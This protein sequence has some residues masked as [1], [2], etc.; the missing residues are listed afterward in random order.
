MA[1]W[2]KLLP[3]F[4]KHGFELKSDENGVYEWRRD[5]KVIKV[6]KTLE[7]GQIV[8][9]CRFFEMFLDTT[10]EV[11]SFIAPPDELDDPTYQMIKKELEK[12]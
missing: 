6:K 8:I 9:S 10:Q 11:L 12:W 1:K 2:S 5:T 7:D 3:L 4:E